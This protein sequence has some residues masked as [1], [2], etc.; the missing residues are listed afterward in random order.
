MH[1]Q[2]DA[3]FITEVLILLVWAATTWYVYITFK[4]SGHTQRKTIGLTLLILG[5]SIYAFGAVKYGFDLKF[6]G[7]LPIRSL[8]YLFLATGLAFAFRWTLVGKGLSQRLLI[9]LQLFR[10]VGLVFI[11]E[12]WRGNL[13]AVF[14]HPAGWGDF[15]VSIIALT[16]LIRYRN[17]VIPN[18]AVIIVFTAGIIDFISAFF[19]GFIFQ[20]PLLQSPAPRPTPVEYR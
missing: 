1:S 19:F 2:M 3:S 7:G 6:F 14:A 20:F 18:G 5:W 10:C 11:L 13:P 15:L 12:H 16:V 9:G 8:V 4:E 17:Q